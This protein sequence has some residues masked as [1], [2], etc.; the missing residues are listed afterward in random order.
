MSLTFA[1]G[2][3]CFLTPVVFLLLPSSQIG[4][5]LWLEIIIRF[6]HV[7]CNLLEAHNCA[8]VL[9]PDG[10]VHLYA[11]MHRDHAQMYPIMP[12]CF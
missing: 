8:N 2:L 12:E 1:L 9:H 11:C 6:Y 5:L 4:C 10:G 7:G 3:S